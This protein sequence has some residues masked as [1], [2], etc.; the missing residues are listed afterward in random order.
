MVLA[1]SL[2][3]G[4]LDLTFSE[5]ETGKPLADVIVQAGGGAE[6][7]PEPA[8]MA[9]KNR[10][11]VPHV[12]VISRGS[13]VTFPNNDNTQHHVYSF[14]PAKPFSI[15]LYAGQPEAPVVFDRA[16]VVELGCNIHDHMQAFILVVDTPHVGRSGSDGRVRL[17]VPDTLLDS[18]S[19]Q[20][21]IWH[22]RLPD[23][24]EAM[25]RVLVGPWPIRQQMTL[26]LAP[27]KPDD[28]GFGGLQKRFREL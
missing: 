9:Q 8:S 19:L 6:L 28:T 25:E 13:A 15:E 20:I 7:A 2:Q 26:E 12:L 4:T 23:N 27:E 17:E 14:S 3:A 21:R 5:S 1:G 22:P 10:E 18:D 24:T 16:G 11:F